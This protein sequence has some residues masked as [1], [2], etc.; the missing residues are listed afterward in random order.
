MTQ[1]QE[2]RTPPQTTLPAVRE[3]KRFEL[4]QLRATQGVLASVPL[5]D[6]LGAIGR[7]ARA[8]WGVV[9]TEDW[10]ANERALERGERLLPSYRT[11]SGT[12]FWIITEWD[13]S[14]TTLLLPEEY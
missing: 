10:A 8:D 4:G 5:E 13:R 1:P 2:P 3:S 12:R 14:A 7:H 6:L 11:K 9:V